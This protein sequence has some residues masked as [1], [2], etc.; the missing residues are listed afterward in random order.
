MPGTC[1]CSCDCICRPQGDSSAGDAA[2]QDSAGG[3]AA[4]GGDGGGDARADAG[5]NDDT[6]PQD[7]AAGDSEAQQPQVIDCADY[8]VLL[9]ISATLSGISTRPLKG[10]PSPQSVPALGA[11]LILSMTSCTVAYTLHE[12]SCMS[13]M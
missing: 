8:L 6:A 7:G 12:S 2:A 11:C 5:A 9:G 13:W 10:I 4:S 3:E 1:T